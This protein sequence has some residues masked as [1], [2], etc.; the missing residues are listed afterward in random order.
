MTFDYF[1]I[2]AKTLVGNIS[3]TKNDSHEINSKPIVTK[4]KFGLSFVMKIIE[5]NHEMKD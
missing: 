1:Q 4:K 5:I 3:F 2:I